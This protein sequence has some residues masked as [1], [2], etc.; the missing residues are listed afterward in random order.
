MEWKDCPEPLKS[1]SFCDKANL[2]KP[3]HAQ[4]IEIHE[5][6]QRIL[7]VFQETI[8]RAIVRISIERADILPVMH[9]SS[10]EL[11]QIFYIMI[12]NM[13][14]SADGVHLHHLDIDFSIQDA[15]FYMKFSEYC[16][17]DSPE[18]IENKPAAV[19]ATF[20]DKDKYNFELSVLKGITEAYGGVITISPN[21]QG[22]FLYEIRIPVV[23]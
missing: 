19:G 3:L 11:E 5:I 8:Q 7:L 10:R 17:N 1:L 21:S 20:P 6:T 15:F 18:N 4:P 12:Q 16:P 9:I 13:I 22:G 14:Q 23:D 2:K